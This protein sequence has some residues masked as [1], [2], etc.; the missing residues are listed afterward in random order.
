MVDHEE[1]PFAGVP[2]LF[3]EAMRE[4]GFKGLTAVQRAVVDAQARDTNLRISSQTGSGKTVAI[5]LGLADSLM[6]A[7]AA[8]KKEDRRAKPRVL[9]IAPTRELAA[10]IQKELAWLYAPLK[11]LRTC[12][13]TGGTDIS[14][15][16]RFLSKGATIVVGTPGRTLDHI[17]AGALKVDE[18]EHVVLDEADHMLDM[19]FKDELDAITEALPAERRSHLVSATFPRAV[20]K[21]ADRYQP[22]ALHLEGTRLGESNADIDHTAYLVRERDQY[23]ALVNLLL[24]TDGARCLVFVKRRID[25]TEIAER[26]S[27]DG[28]SA[29]PFSGDLP[30][31]QRTRTLNAFRNDVVRILVATDVAARGIDVADIATVVHIDL[32]FDA[33][34]YTHRSGR[35]GRA[36]QK[37][38]SILLAP[39]R[40]ENRLRR[41]LRQAKVDV[42]WSTL[43]GPDRIQKALK[44]RARKR[45]HGAMESEEVPPEKILE[46]AEHLL[47]EYDPKI[48][49][50]RLIELARP[51]LPREPMAYASPLRG[52][53]RK[54]KPR[55]E[56]GEYRPFSIAF[57]IKDGATPARALATICRRGDIAGKQIGAIRIGDDETCFEV[58]VGVAEKFWVNAQKEDDRRP[59]Q[60][61]EQ[62]DE[63]PA[64]MER[65]GSFRNDFKGK[66]GGKG[67]R[68]S[69]GG[70][71]G[72]GRGGYDRKGGRRE[73]NKPFKPRGRGPKK[74]RFG[75]RD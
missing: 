62:I 63:M 27:A 53:E 74:N 9:L 5:G 33:E 46:Y 11:G 48:L 67:Y 3:V 36:G 21:F 47:G 60:V 38:R 59:E 64:R 71:D 50:A 28:F 4:R 70:R 41:T 49:V 65:S 13:V 7:L 1:D 43:P 69:K 22:D 37:G 12:V 17:Q 8:Q 73:G 24:L 25:T 66:R 20:K 39:P 19:G 54:S 57:G 6:E 23:A 35:T 72:G 75:P 51:V 2:A 10:Q 45:I 34:T 30:Q 42:D 15:E 40:S 16:R 29:L 61:I 55:N 14:R 56:G 26:L 18:I 58:D 32:P 44:K 31:G 52:G 68:S